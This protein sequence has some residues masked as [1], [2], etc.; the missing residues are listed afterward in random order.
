MLPALARMEAGA[1]LV[2]GKILDRADSALPHTADTLRTWMS[3]NAGR[4]VHGQRAAAF[5][6][7]TIAGAIDNSQESRPKAFQREGKSS[8]FIDG[9]VRCLF[10]NRQPMHE[11]GTLFMLA[12]CDDVFRS[13]AAWCMRHNTGV[14]KHRKQ[15]TT[16]M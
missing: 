11:V 16:V 5:T 13:V 3:R 9:C 7:L 2:N 15:T 8:S 12:G 1:L 6:A 10:R 4:V 14:R